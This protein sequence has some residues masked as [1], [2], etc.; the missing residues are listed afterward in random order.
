MEGKEN[1]KPKITTAKNN[2][3]NNRTNSPRNG[4]KKYILTQKKMQI[5]ANTIPERK[6]QKR[7]D[8][9]T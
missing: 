9:E 7:T 5:K 6:Q 8:C 4:G 1:N 3:E 2:S